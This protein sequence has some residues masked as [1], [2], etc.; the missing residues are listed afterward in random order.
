MPHMHHYVFPKA[1][2]NNKIFMVK[3]D[4]KDRFWRM[5]FRAGEEWNFTYVL[6]PPPG[7]PVWLVVLTLLQMGWVE[8]PPFFYGN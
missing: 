5:D 8:L 3:W 7:E 4:I 6:P 1:D 2:N